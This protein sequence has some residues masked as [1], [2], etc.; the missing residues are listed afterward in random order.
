M[1]CS[2]DVLLCESVSS[3][4]YL[5][6]LADNASIQGKPFCIVVLDAQLCPRLLGFWIVVVSGNQLVNIGWY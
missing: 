4:P 6:M 1:Q 2:D 5:A 3:E